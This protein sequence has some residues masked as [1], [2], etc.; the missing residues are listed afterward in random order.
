MLPKE[1][2]PSAQKKEKKQEQQ[3]PAVFFA[4]TVQ[5]KLTFNSKGQ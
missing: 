4:V 3:A 5:A 2:K 1:E